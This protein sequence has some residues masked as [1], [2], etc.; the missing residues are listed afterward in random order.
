MIVSKGKKFPR[1]FFL[2][3]SP[4]FLPIRYD[5]LFFFLFCFQGNFIHS[6]FE[7]NGAAT[8][9]FPCVEMRNGF[10]PSF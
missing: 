7:G 2:S 1:F 9:L 6:L 5:F 3:L 10:D 4:F 8:A